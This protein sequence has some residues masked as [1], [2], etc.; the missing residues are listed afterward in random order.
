[1]DELKI[2]IWIVLGLI[3]LFARKKKKPAP[4]VQQRRVES[5]DEH[6]SPSPSKPMTFEDLLREIQGSKKPDP[7]S[8]K[9]PEPVYEAPQQKWEPYHYEEEV[10]VQRKPLEDTNYDYRKH[11]KIYEEYDNAKKY[12]FVKPSLEETMKIE[13]T[14]VRF[15][16]FKEYAPDPRHQLRQDIVKEFKNPQSFKKAFILSEILQRKF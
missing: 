3:Y 6:D 7:V 16:P 11:D 8:Q 10:V 15:N 4:P 9:L 14:V 1:M 2:L 13:D 12:A 5:Q